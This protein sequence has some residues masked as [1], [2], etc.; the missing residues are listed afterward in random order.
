MYH[1]PPMG[2]YCKVIYT[3][4]LFGI[5]RKFSSAFADPVLNIIT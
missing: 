2:I 5:T 1:Q 4:E 3:E